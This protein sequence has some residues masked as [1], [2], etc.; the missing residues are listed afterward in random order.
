MTP[1]NQSSL[2]CASICGGRFMALLDVVV[3]AMRILSDFFAGT[4]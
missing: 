2:S 4:Q 3:F 1:G